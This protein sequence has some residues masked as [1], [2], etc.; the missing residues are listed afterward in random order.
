M[1]RI[2]NNPNGLL[3]VDDILSEHFGADSTTDRSLN[4]PYCECWREGLSGV[5]LVFIHG[6]MSR[7]NARDSWADGLM[8]YARKYDLSVYA[9]RWNSSSWTEVVWSALALPISLPLS[10]LGLLFSAVSEFK[11]ARDLADQ[12]G[13]KLFSLINE[14]PGQLLLVGHSLGGRIVMKGL[15]SANTKQRSKII[16][17]VALAPAVTERAVYVRAEWKRSLVVFSKSDRILNH[18]YPKLEDEQA[19]GYVGPKYK[20]SITL[21]VSRRDI[22]HTEYAPKIFSILNHKKTKEYLRQRHHVFDA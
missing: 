20:G 19:L 8:R 5:S 9:L 15:K 21:D 3:S 16:G 17:S 14:I 10:I 22:G 2:I 18:I 1:L 6:F 7:D 13:A 12:H 4:Y 11:S